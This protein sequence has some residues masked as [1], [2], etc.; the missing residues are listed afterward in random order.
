VG[1]SASSPRAAS[2]ADSDLNVLSITATDGAN[3]R[4]VVSLLRATGIS[5]RAVRHGDLAPA[6]LEGV[7]VIVICGA[8]APVAAKLAGEA[9]LHHAQ[10]GIV[11][12]VQSAEPRELRDLLAAG[13]DGVVLEAGAEDTLVVTIRAV[14]TGQLVVPAELWQR[15]AR[16]ALSTREKQALAMVVMGFSNAE[17]ARKLY[18]TEATVKSHLSSAFAKLG[19]RSRSE[20]TARILDPEH[21][22]GTGILAISDDGHTE[23]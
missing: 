2:S 18:V 13:A 20:A 22:L 10:A 15:T 1:I 21:G 4:A 8:S 5:T 7:D 23:R 17:I 19:V 9:R 12:V 3:V 6:S 11:T 14:T 16:P